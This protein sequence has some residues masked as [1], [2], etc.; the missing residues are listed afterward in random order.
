VVVGSADGIIQTQRWKKSPNIYVEV[1][2][3]E[4]VELGVQSRS[5][6]SGGQI[7][8]HADLDPEMSKL[9]M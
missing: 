6:A 5:N 1:E 2:V 7:S 3:E 9:I 4:L 8:Q